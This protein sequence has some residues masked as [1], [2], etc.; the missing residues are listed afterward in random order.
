MCG[1]SPPTM[2]PTVFLCFSH[3]G[4]DIWPCELLE[5]TGGD[6]ILTFRC[7]KLSGFSENGVTFRQFLHKGGLSG[8]VFGRDHV[9]SDS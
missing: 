1:R 7:H 5:A 4:L 8:H 3:T 6:Y 2:W 9:S